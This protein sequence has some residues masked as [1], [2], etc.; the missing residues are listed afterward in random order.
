[1]SLFIVAFRI[2]YDTEARYNRC[3]EELTSAIVAE[4][5]PKYWAEATSLYLITSAKNSS[6]LANAIWSE[7]VSF[8]DKEDLLVVINIS[9]TKGHSV[10]GKLK[11]GDFSAL[12][13]GRTS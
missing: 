2:N 6:D 9:T 1:L 11:D 4:S 8:D 3:Y 7:A 13:A 5:G 12:M 10:K